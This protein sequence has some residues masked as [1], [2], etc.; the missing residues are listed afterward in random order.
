M[1][2]RYGYHLSPSGTC[3][4]LMYDMASYAPFSL[5]RELGTFEGRFRLVETNN[6]Q[7]ES[8]NDYPEP[9]PQPECQ[10]T[11]LNLASDPYPASQDTLE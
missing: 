6:A 10:K 11:D 8:S 5:R 7:L 2:I 1:L 9:P 3:C 4:T